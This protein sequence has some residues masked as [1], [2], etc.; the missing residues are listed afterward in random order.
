MKQMKL[1]LSTIILSLFVIAC[2]GTS[3]SQDEGTTA[4]ALGQFGKDT[5]L[6]A[7]TSEVLELTMSSEGLS[8]QNFD[9]KVGQGYVLKV[10]NNTTRP[11][12]IIAYRHGINQ[13]VPPGETI[14]T[15]PFSDQEVGFVEQ[16]REQSR[17]S[18]KKWQFTI[19]VVE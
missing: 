4:V 7:E 15:A 2:G 13:V 5:T 18:Q 3:E 14:T 11:R 12:F 8:P 6:T 10:T 17:G 1:L 16:G 9:I 19:T